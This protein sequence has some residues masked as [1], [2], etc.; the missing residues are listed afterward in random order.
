M[1]KSWL[2]TFLTVVV[3]FGV[4]TLLYLYTAGYR[5]NRDDQTIDIKR[6]G[7]VG[8]KSIPEG[9]KIYIDGIIFGATDNT[10][11][12]LEPKTYTLRMV[13][14]GFVAWT[15]TVEVFPELV[16]DITAV[17]VSQSPRLEPLT[18]TG[19]RSPSISPTLS[20]IA[21]FSKD[22]TSPGV[23]V[24]PL[25][26]EGLNLFRSNANNILE[27]TFYNQYSEGTSIEWSPDEKNI[28]I[29]I[30]AGEESRFYNVDLTDGT[31]QATASPELLRESWRTELLEKRSDFIERIEIPEEMVAIATRTD[32]VW[33]PDNKKFLYRVVTV[34]EFE[35]RVY[36]MEK[37]L[38]VGEKVDTL[39]FT[40]STL[41][42]QPKVN[43][44]SDSFHLILAELEEQSGTGKVSLIRIDGSNLTEVYNNTLHSDRVFSA[45]GGDKLIILTSFKSG[46]Q[47][48]LYT[49][50]IR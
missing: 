17:L 9:A 45:P 30:L 29:E 50:G 4:T 19:A 47:T 33:A 31:A 38:P 27:D 40:T 48:D 36:N 42:P 39:V 8:A 44:Y 41:D 7:M 11:P 2:Q 14:N 49:V 25:V 12:G 43:W 5:I 10:I 16:T 23:W 1:R 18:N 34:S 21:F 20:K 24:I 37:P 46:D 35:Y 15:K 28:L 26:N 13:K 6:T 32:T 22:A 3:L